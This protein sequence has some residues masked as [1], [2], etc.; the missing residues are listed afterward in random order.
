MPAR[1]AFHLHRL[2]LTGTALVERA[3]GS[4]S[5]KAATAIANARMPIEDGDVVGMCARFGLL[6]DD[7]M[8][9]LTSNEAYA[10][11]YYRISDKHRDAVWH[12]AQRAWQNANVP[13]SKVA[14][15]MR[16]P[17]SLV[18]RQINRNRDATTTL[19]W[20]SAS[21]LAALVCCSD[22]HP[23]LPPRY[24]DRELSLSDTEAT[25]GPDLW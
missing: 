7:L 25:T 10:W 6:P 11:A 1:V 2:R 24:Q 4:L 23:F 5:M 8:R 17:R 3:D 12:N 19:T 15:V 14:A 21:R 9:H 20:P 18:Y 22:R 16:M 13:V